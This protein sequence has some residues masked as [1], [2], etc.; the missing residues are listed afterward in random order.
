MD[1][2]SKKKV[3]W[4]TCVGILLIWIASLVGIYGDSSTAQ[5]ALMTLK[6]TGTFIVST[7]LIAGGVTDG[8]KSDKVRVAMV[9]LGVLVLFVLL[10]ATQMPMMPL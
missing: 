8:D 5:D 6:N 1:I 2:F 10:Q 4:A 9:V 3:A 7:M